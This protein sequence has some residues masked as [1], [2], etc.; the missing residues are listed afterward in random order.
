MK[1]LLQEE[2]RSICFISGLQEAYLISPQCCYKIVCLPI[3]S[4]K[5]N[6][7]TILEIFFSSQS[8]VCSSYWFH[9][10]FDESTPSHPITLCSGSLHLV[11]ICWQN[12]FSF[13]V[14]LYFKCCFFLR[15]AL[16]QKTRAVATLFY[17]SQISMWPAKLPFSSG[18]LAAASLDRNRPNAWNTNVFSVKSLKLELLM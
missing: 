10:T 3:G 1:I 7:P 8:T 5:M 11:N 16:K 15:D 6:K 9:P 2:S 17:S 13:F 18:V 12:V 14:V 4:L